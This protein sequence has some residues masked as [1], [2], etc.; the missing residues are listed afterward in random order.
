MLFIL[1]KGIYSQIS[2]CPTTAVEEHG[3]YPVLF[4][5]YEWKSELKKRC[6]NRVINAGVFQVSRINLVAKWTE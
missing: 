6:R 5:Q 1:P 3:N 4:C 2:F